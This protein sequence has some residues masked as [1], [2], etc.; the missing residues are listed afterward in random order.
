MIAMLHFR[1]EFSGDY[2]L[3]VYD[4]PT[5]QRVS[6]HSGAMNSLAFSPD[7]KVIA[8]SGVRRAFLVDAKT[9]QELK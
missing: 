4:V 1:M 8:T 5:L 9:G 7:G 2:H 3:E 6:K